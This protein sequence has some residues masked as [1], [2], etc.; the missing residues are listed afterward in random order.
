MMSDATLKFGRAGYVGSV[1]VGYYVYK[2]T[3]STMVMVGRLVFVIFF[4]GPGRVG[5]MFSL[6]LLSIQPWAPTQSCGEL[7]VESEVRA[8]R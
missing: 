7:L 4:R 2:L 8:A 6:V 1:V 3:E 5:L